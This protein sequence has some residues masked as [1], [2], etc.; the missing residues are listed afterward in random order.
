MNVQQ[1]R[2]EWAFLTNAKVFVA[3]SGGV[4]SV[5]LLHVL[6]SFCKDV[7]VIHINYGL[8]G[9]E[10]DED[11][12]FVRAICSQ[13]KVPLFVKNVDTKSI[14]SDSGGNLQEVARDIRYELFD[15]LL[16]KNEEGYVVLGQ[17]A[18]DQVETF[19][20]HLARK[21][22]VLGMACMLPIHN[23][24]V[25]PFLK[26][27][28]AELIEYAI[29]NSIQWREDSSNQQNKYTRNKLRNVYLPLVEKE[30]PDLV[31]SVLL[32]VDAFQ[33]TQS[34]IEDSARSIVQDILVTLYWDGQIFDQTPNEVRV[35]VIR[36]LGGGYEVLEQ[37]E[38]IRFSQKGK[39]IACG[40]FQFFKEKEGFSLRNKLVSNE[41]ELLINE[42]NKLP[43][44]FSKEV[45][46][47]DKSKISGDLRVRPWRIGDRIAPIGMKG[48]KLISDV[49]TE[50]KIDSSIRDRCLVVLD[51]NEIIWCVGYKIS[52]KAVP[53][54][55]T[56]KILEVKIVEKS[57]VN[58]K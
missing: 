38:K 34:R 30:I 20:Q 16:T 49:L 37:L 19:F 54:Q 18:D 7:E 29:S 52:R 13:L 14:L 5:V 45:I 9:S 55:E 41:C 43:A 10:S 32:L 8:R 44:S 23:R 39:M 15:S 50:A 27:S 21:S 40:D 36:Q 2:S 24:Y 4:D 51:E 28:K 33:E 35:D 26:V 47:L 58:F 22:G 11:E 57:F 3:C 48:T 53:T 1:L 31:S 17:H 12:Q 25:R 6:N 56:L 42:V 46:Y